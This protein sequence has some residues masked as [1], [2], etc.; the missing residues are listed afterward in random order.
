MY[1]PGRTVLIIC[2]MKM[3]LGCIWLCKRFHRIVFHFLMDRSV[4]NL[5]RAQ[6]HCAA[7]FHPPLTGRRAVPSPSPL[8]AQTDLPLRPLFGPYAAFTTWFYFLASLSTNFFVRGSQL[9]ALIFIYGPKMLPLSGL[10]SKA[11]KFSWKEMQN[12]IISSRP[13]YQ[14]LISRLSNIGKIYHLGECTSILFTN[15][16]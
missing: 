1:Y 5:Y 14:G 8:S 9:V 3:H 12:S 13:K 7:S 16:I 15:S 4:F 11:T 2:C 6:T 10:I